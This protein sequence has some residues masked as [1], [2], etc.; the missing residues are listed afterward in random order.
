VT[1]RA[2]LGTLWLLLATTACGGGAEVGAGAEGSWELVSGTHEGG[3]VAAPAG[4]RITLVIDGDEVSGTAACNQY[5]GAATI[6]GDTFSIEELSHTE[7]GCPALMD[8]EAA[9]LDALTAVDSIRVAGD[10]LVLGGDATELTF[11]PLPPVPTAELVDTAWRLDTLLS[12]DT[13][14]SA[15]DGGSLRL[16][17]DGAIEGSTGCRAFSGRYTLRGDEV[18]VTQ[19]TADE[20]ACTEALQWQDDHVVQVLGDGFRATVEGGRLTLESGRLG[21]AFRAD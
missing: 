8:A 17:R 11:A 19:L 10:R 3:R 14:A 16:T 13:A 21:L 1:C 20:G 5:G 7:M 18:V 4:A 9:F 15:D 6:D 12:G 2:V